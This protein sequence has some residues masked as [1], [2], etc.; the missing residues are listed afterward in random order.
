MARSVG[1]FSVL[2]TYAGFLADTNYTMQNVVDWINTLTDFTATLLDDTRAACALQAFGTE[3][4]WGAIDVKTAAVDL[5]GAIRLHADL[6]QTS[7]ES[8]IFVNNKAFDMTGEQHLFMKDGT[9][10]DCFVANNLMHEDTP[11]TQTVGKSQLAEPQSHVLWVHNTNTSQGASLRPDIAYNPDAYC[12]FANNAFPSVQWL[13]TPDADLVIRDNHLFSGASIP[14]NAT[15]TTTGGDKNDW[16]TD[17][18]NGNFTPS[19]TLLTNMKTPVLVRD[20][21]NN[22]RGATSPTGGLA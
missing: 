2:N 16:A 9:S 19:G 10:R 13:G 12:L 4:P 1:T 7:G 21:E 8:Y 3:G 20:R 15:G 17:P 11:G 18:V 14:A 22:L 6:W 5:S